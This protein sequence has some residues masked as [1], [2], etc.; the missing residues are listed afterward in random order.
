MTCNF[1]KMSAYL[2]RIFGCKIIL[3]NN[4]SCA[5]RSVLKTYRK[6]RLLPFMIIFSTA[7]LSSKMSNF[8]PSWEY[9]AFEETKSTCDNSRKFFVSDCFFSDALIKD[10]FLRSGLTF[11]FRFESECNTSIF[12]SQNQVREFHPFAI[13]YRKK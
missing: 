11:C 6:L 7:S 10:G 5:T 1:V 8:V 12:K 3:S 13:L 4:E 9:F 2:I